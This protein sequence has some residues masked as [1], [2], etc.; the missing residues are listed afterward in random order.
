MRF[1]AR[2]V[3]QFADIFIG[4]AELGDACDVPARKHSLVV[5][6]RILHWSESAKD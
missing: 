1:L 3:A 6:A 5:F 2:T 4:S